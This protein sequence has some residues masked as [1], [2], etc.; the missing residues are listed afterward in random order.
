MPR[1]APRQDRSGEIDPAQAV[2]MTL[3]VRY[4]ETDQMGV[5]HHAN[6]FIWFEAA[7]AAFCRARGVDYAQMERDG[8]ILPVIEARC[9]FLRGAHYDEEITVRVWV[10]ECR[11]SLLSMQ[12]E[13]RRGEDLLAEG[14]TLQMLVERA[15]G[16]PRRFPPELAARFDADSEA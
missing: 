11:R 12:Y 5:A 16:K 15:S 1:R 14:E 9:R 13:V 3:R 4:A 10:V 8:L 2:E 7:R 6:Y